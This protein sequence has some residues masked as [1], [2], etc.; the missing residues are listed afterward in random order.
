MI[1]YKNTLSDLNIM[2]EVLAGVAGHG[3]WADTQAGVSLSQQD[4]VPSDGTGGEDRTD[5]FLL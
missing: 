2:P 4:W 1:S 3:L 5:L